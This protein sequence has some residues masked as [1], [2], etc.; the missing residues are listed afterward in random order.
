M[1]YKIISQ[2]TMMASNFADRQNFRRLCVLP[3]V[4]LEFGKQ[5]GALDLYGKFYKSTEFWFCWNYD[6][7]Q[8]RCQCE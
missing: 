8:F 5:E 3:V 6:R 1:R 7:L 4:Q 2:F